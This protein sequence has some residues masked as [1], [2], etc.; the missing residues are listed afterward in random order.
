MV[1]RQNLNVKTVTR[2]N[3]VGRMVPKASA[4]LSLSRARR[5]CELESPTST[6]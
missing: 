5:P 1:L 4:S 3:Q 6:E 2:D